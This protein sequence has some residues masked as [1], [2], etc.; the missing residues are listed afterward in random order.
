MV[1]ECAVME[2]NKK[3]ITMPDKLTHSVIFSFKWTLFRIKMLI[4]HHPRLSP[5]DG[6]TYSSEINI[7]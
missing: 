6:I 3:S 4:L 2:T 1:A 5:E 7:Q